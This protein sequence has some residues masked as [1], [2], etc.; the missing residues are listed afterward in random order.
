MGGVQ[1]DFSDN[2]TIYRSPLG[3]ND[4]EI[5][6]VAPVAF[7]SQRPSFLYNDHFYMF[8]NSSDLWKYDP[9][10]N[11]FSYE[12]SND[13]VMDNSVGVVIGDKLI[14]GMGRDT[15]IVE[16]YDLSIGVWKPKNVYPGII[17][18]F[19]SAWWTNE[20]KMY[21]LRTN[22]RNFPGSSDRMEIWSL[23]PDKL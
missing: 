14:V 7:N 9:Q 6:G 16:E 5:V 1:A 17:G 23:D 4:W 22:L 10:T 11:E 13:Q 3:S 20:G 15:K 2:L 12:T 8:S 18:E 21:V 19:N